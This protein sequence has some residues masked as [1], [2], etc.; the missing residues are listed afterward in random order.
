MKTLGHVSA[1]F[2]A[3][4]LHPLAA[5]EAVADPS[6]S[7]A[8]PIEHK[9]PVPPRVVKA[10]IDKD[11]DLDLCAFKA[12]TGFPIAW[13]ENKGDGKLT[14]HEIDP[15]MTYVFHMAVGDIDKDGDNDLLAYG[16]VAGLVWYENLERGKAFSRHD[17][18][19]PGRASSVGIIDVDGDGNRD[20]VYVDYDKVGWARNE[21]GK[22]GKWSA[23]QSLVTGGGKDLRVAD[24]D[25]DGD[26]DIVLVQNG[27]VAVLT[28]KKGTFAAKSVSGPSE[29]L[30]VADLDNDG[31]PDIVSSTGSSIHVLQNV[32]GKAFAAKELVSGN[33]VLF[34]N[35]DVGDFDG[36]RRLD[37][38]A[39]RSSSP[40]TIFFNGGEDK[41]T[42]KPFFEDPD[43]GKKLTYALDMNGDKKED[44]VVFPPVDG[45]VYWLANGTKR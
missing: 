26:E 37:V 39:A 14:H 11:G 1:M 42:E 17:I 13:L 10:D 3:L 8:K 23:L 21:D 32:G 29:L 40:S 41:W 34:E 12:Y 2:V 7:A 33:M 45:G 25:K 20:I 15:D 18:A 31:Y 28:N 36:N 30:T 35:V 27:K 4:L 9:F 24:M 16:N 22:G 5:P 44:I 38:I 43:G 19:D 6:F